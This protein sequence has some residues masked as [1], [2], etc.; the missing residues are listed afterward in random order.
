MIYYVYNTS[1]N[2]V[3][4]SLFFPHLGNQVLR[5]AGSR[6]RLHRGGGA[7]EGELF[8][9]AVQKTMLNGRVSAMG[10]KKWEN[11]L[12]THRDP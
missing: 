12:E 9:G 8:L 2:R 6:C 10:E 3:T 4:S 5:G 7:D 11:L 1:H